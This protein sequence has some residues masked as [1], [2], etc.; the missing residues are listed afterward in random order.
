MRQETIQAIV[1][2]LKGTLLEHT[3]GRVF[4]LSPLSFAIDFG[5]RTAGYLFVSA[6]PAQPRIHLIKR[7]ARELEKQSQPPTLFAQSLRSLLAGAQLVTIVRDE[8]ER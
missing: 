8:T 1:A 3:V 5:V 7:S 4:Q 2:E 6:E